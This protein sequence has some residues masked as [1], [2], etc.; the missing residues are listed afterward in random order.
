MYTISDEQDAPHEC[1]ECQT[2]VGVELRWPG[3]GYTM[4]YRCA[5]CGKRRVEREQG[6]IERNFQQGPIGDDVGAFDPA[7]AG[8]AFDEEL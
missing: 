7:D 4:F 1:I 6:N 8:E 3:Y 2:T 5:P